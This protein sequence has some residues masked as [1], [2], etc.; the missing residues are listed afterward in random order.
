M[1]ISRGVI[2]ETMFCHQTSGPTG[3]HI[4][5][6]SVVPDDSKA[7]RTSKITPKVVL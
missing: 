2:T 5:S 4:P 6:C 3:I 7:V 1:L